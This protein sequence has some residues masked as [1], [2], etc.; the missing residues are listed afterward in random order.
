MMFFR[1]ILI[2]LLGL[3]TVAAQNGIKVHSHND[4]HQKT[5]FWGAFAS[6]VNS[7]EVDLILQNGELYVAHEK[8]SIKPNF[9][10]EEL[11]LKPLRNIAEVYGTS[12]LDFQLMLD[13]KTEAESTL[14]E[15]IK[16]IEP[17]K[18]LCNPY[19][20]QGV[21]VTISGHR[22]KP[23]KYQTYPE[24]IYFDCQETNQTRGKAWDKVAMISVSFKNFSRWNGLGRMVTNEQNLV[25]AFIKRTKPYKKPIRF[26]ATPDTKTAWRTLSRMGVDYI[27]TDVPE[28]AVPYLQ[29]MDKR[30]FKGEYTPYEV[31]QPTFRHN[32]SANKVKNIIFMIGDGTG[33]SQISSGDVVQSNG[34]NITQLKN[35][36]L[37]RTQASDNFCTDS[38]AGATAY[39]T[40][41]QTNN[42][43]IGTDIEGNPLTNITE[44]LSPKGYTTG[45]I[46]TDHVIGATPA[47]FYAH[48]K[49]R[50]EDFAITE[51]MVESKLDFFAGAGKRDFNKVMS[52]LKAQFHVYDTI[53]NTFA[54][55]ERIGLFLS[56]GGLQRMKDGRSNLMPELVKQVLPYLK[57]KEKPFFIMIEGAKIDSYGH[58]N[59]MDAMLQELFDFDA[60]VGEALKFADKDGETLVV[61]TADHETGGLS[62]FDAPS[63]SNELEG[64]FTTND[65][66]GT[67]VPIFAYGP[68]SELFQGVYN[69][70]EVNHKFLQL[71]HIKRTP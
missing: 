65:H 13:V 59:D 9:T 21:M 27:N 8:E 51:D 53:P 70:Y 68:G 15:I 58:A 42:R 28:K 12:R 11:Y 47:A 14:D 56:Q 66:T 67:L 3:L 4:Y 32:E 54:P 35:L 46:T 63:G 25:E 2:F 10:F 7:I 5:P 37:V 36:G 48:V 16:A 33:L 50:G 18:D 39:A 71:L 34:L 44:L 61:I 62:L 45:L 30:T 22:P 55:E 6:G 26:W 23:E 52:K 41:K 64:D 24:H 38:A 43:A 57:A 40:G 17:Y 60:M 1:T 20:E 31:Y 29:S 69:N 19:L 49:D